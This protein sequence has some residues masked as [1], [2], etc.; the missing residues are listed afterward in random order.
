MDEMF[1]LLARRYGSIEIVFWAQKE[2]QDSG[3]RA[4]LV[5]KIMLHH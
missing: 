5:V 2:R 3:V 1:H 4:A